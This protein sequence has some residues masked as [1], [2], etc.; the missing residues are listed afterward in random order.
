MLFLKK[1]KE[2]LSVSLSDNNHKIRATLSHAMFRS[3]EEI[4][5][6]P[7]QTLILSLQRRMA[8]DRREG[9]V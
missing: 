6:S 4:C 3:T 5:C 8:P 2:P 7:D 9:M 1:R